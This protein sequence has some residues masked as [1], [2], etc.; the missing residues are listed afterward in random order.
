MGCLSDLNGQVVRKAESILSH[1]SHPLHHEFQELPS[2]SWYGFPTVKTNKYKHSFTPTTIALFNKVKRRSASLVELVSLPLWF[3]FF[4]HGDYDDDYVDNDD[5][6]GNVMMMM[7]MI[8]MVTLLIMI[9]IFSM[10]LT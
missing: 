7:M 5:G 3:F 6:G 9:V 2:G 8:I 1:C 4:I 10:M